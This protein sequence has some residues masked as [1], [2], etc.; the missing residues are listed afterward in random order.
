MAR[1]APFVVFAA[2]EDVVVDCYAA[3]KSGRRTKS[4]NGWV[5]RAV[6]RLERRR[7][8]QQLPANVVAGS[9]LKRR[10][11]RVIEGKRFNGADT[12][13]PTL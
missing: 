4:N 1:Y 12:T 6:A 3:Q 10:H 11:Y 9:A 5:A 2:V 7:C 8:P 13:H